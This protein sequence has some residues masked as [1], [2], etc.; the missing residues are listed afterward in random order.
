MHVDSF[1]IYGSNDQQYLT[2]PEGMH[3]S[4]LLTGSQPWCPDVAGRGCMKTLMKPDFRL[5]GK[6]AFFPWTA[7]P[8]QDLLRAV[9]CPQQPLPIRYFRL[10]SGYGLD[11]V[12]QSR[13]KVCSLPPRFHLR[14]WIAS[15][16][17]FLPLH[18]WISA[19]LY[20]KCLLCQSVCFSSFSLLYLHVGG[21]DYISWSAVLPYHL[22]TFEECTP[23]LNHDCHD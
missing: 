3:F 23:Q 8:T 7:P 2:S 12:C 22:S 16:A 14:Q 13:L 15:G 5:S 21:M 10:E 17:V 1:H 6:G 18:P 9:Y 11:E 20:I 4:F 19:V